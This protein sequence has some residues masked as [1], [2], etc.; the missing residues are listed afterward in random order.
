[1]A[2]R[3]KKGGIGIKDGVAVSVAFIA[4]DVLRTVF[5]KGKDGKVVERPHS[6]F[7]EDGK[8]I[9]TLDDTYFFQADYRQMFKMAGKIIGEP[10][11]K[12]KE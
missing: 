3:V 8:Q 4:N 5:I 10:R 9:R 2:V 6:R 1:L 11:R 12:P 7:R